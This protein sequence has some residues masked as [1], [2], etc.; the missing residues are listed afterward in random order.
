MKKRKSKL[1]TISN[2]ISFFY[3]VIDRWER[4]FDRQTVIGTLCLLFVSRN[5]CFEDELF[6]ILKL[7]NYVTW[8]LFFT[9]LRSFVLNR[10]GLLSF[11]NE[12]IRKAV[13]ARYFR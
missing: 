5:G 9:H 8:S 13:R 4:D 7:T 10:S 11:A 2:L 12:E 3:L 6:A 1:D